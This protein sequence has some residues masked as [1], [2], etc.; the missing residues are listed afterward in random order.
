[1]KEI[2]S[3]LMLCHDIESV[4]YTHLDV[5][6]RQGL[7]ILILSINIIIFDY[8]IM[9]EWIIITVNSCN[10]YI[11]LIFDFMST[12]FLSTVMFISSMVI[13]YRGTYIISDKNY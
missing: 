4:S 8:I 6:K 10:I 5:Y 2:L 12:L 7:M 3:N 1:M 13:L 9:I 11:T